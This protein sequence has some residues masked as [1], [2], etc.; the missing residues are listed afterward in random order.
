MKVERFLTGIISTNCYLAVNE[1]TRQTIVVDPAASPSY[2]M[3]HI[4]SEG[5]QIEAIFLTHG[6]FDH[7][8]GL[9]GFLKE[10]DVP[11]YIHEDDDEVLRDPQLNL[12]GSYTSGYVFDRAKTVKDGEVLHYAGYDFR[13]IHTPGHTKGGCCYYVAEEG[14]L[15]SGDTLFQA[16]VG[17]TDFPNSS[18]SDLLRSIREKLMVLPDETKVY[19]GHMGETTIGSERMHNP[20]I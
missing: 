5:L 4:R 14:V 1:K 12:S 10:Y 16:S 19:P 13:V 20:F 9:D 18:T 6:H 8:M 15:F 11:V 7:T 3:N 2:L 17:R